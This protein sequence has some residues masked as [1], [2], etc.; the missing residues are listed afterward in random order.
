MTLSTEHGAIGMGEVRC[1]MTIEV[2]D[3]YSVDLGDT[4]EAVKTNDKEATPSRSTP[5]TR[6]C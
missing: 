4:I 2:P 6:M 3:D 5:P 1:T